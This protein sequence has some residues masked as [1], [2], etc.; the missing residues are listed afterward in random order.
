[1]L[2]GPVA[3][4][5]M[6]VNF[7]KTFPNTRTCNFYVGDGGDYSGFISIVRVYTVL[8]RPLKLRLFKMGFKLRFLASQA[9]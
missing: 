8:Q 3:L 6:R 4:C 9:I 7:F 2:S 1:M 5:L